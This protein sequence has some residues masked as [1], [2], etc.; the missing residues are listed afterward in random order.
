M[1]LIERKYL[2]YKQRRSLINYT[3]LDKIL[4][5]ILRTKKKHRLKLEF[6][7]ADDICILKSAKHF[8]AGGKRR[9]KFGN[10]LFTL[11]FPSEIAYVR[12]SFP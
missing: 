11:F 3:A 2:L 10:T 1:Y 6:Y 9:L 5:Q 7:F 8:R 4:D 12:F